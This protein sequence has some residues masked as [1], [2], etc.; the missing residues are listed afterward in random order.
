MTTHMI[1]VDYQGA[2]QRYALGGSGNS[3]E[4]ED[5]DETGTDAENIGRLKNG[6]GELWYLKGVD[7][8]GEFAP[9]D[10]KV[11]T[12]PIRDFV[13]SMASITSTPLHY[14][15]KTGS[16]PSGESLRT[17]ESPLIVKVK[18]RQITFGS[19]WADMFRFIL[20]M[21]NSTEPNI[22]VRWKDIESIDSLDAWEVAVKKR[23]VGVS[24]EQV[25]IE[26]GY[27]LEV[28]KQI[29]ATEESLTSLSQNTN[30]N[31]VIMEAT[32]GQIGNE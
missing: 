31:N 20:K 1:T 5:F 28:A 7:K 29:A 2:P 6:P 4:F 23:V 14:F 10:H 17:A 13:R 12:E 15:E 27:D 30:T 26:M 21:E 16:I 22:Q 32:G 25:L 3:S 24:L 18:D 9:A 19:T 11:F 8:V